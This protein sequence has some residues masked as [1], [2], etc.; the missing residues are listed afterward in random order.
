MNTSVFFHVAEYEMKQQGRS[1]L[2][3]FFALF[4]LV[5]IVSCHVYWQGPGAGNWKMVAFPCSMPLVNAYLYSVI[6][7]LF[8]VVMMS[9]IPRRLDHRGSQE[10]LLA[11]PVSNMTYLWGVVTGNGLLFLSMNVVV[12]LSSV[13]LVN[14][15]SLAPVS[16]SCYLFYLLT[17]TLPSWLFVAGFSFWLSS[18]TG[19]RYLA[20]FFSLAWLI[21]CLF[22]LPYVQHGTLDYTGSGV[23][24]LFSELVGH[25]NLPRYLLHRLAYSLLGLGLLAWSVSR[26]KR[27]PNCR[28]TRETQVLVG[29]LFLLVGLGCTF[30]LEYSYYRDRSAREDYRSSFSR[31]WREETCRVKKHAIRL[32]QKGKN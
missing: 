19:S 20:I 10:A 31:H 25:L 5:G 11:R 24:N 26:F 7:S 8:L 32:R 28:S 14:L 13:F 23:P 22:W 15:T 21:G 6:Q 2:F 30:L 3:R 1:W 17:L 18:V 4:S 9:E 29:L 16:W 27:I 12:I